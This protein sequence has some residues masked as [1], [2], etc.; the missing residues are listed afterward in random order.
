MPEY[1][2][3]EKEISSH[4]SDREDSDIKNADKKI[5]MK[6]IKYKICLVFIFLMSQMKKS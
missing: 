5:L 6:I 4:D 1:I 2:T 3:D